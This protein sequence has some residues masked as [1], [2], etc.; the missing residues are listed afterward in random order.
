MNWPT[1]VVM[2]LALRFGPDLVIPESLERPLALDQK[3]IRLAEPEPDT[4]AGEVLVRVPPL[5]LNP[6]PIVMPWITLAVEPEPRS[7]F[8]GSDPKPV[9]PRATPKVPAVISVVA[10]C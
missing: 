7:R 4:V 6:V 3:A 1:F 8:A 10:L 9:P 5:R 2:I